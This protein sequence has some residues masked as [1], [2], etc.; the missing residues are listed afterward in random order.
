MRQMSDPVDHEFVWTWPGTTMRPGLCGHK[1]PVSNAVPCN[2]TARE[3]L[4]LVA[5]YGC[6]FCS[7]TA[8]MNVRCSC[9]D[10][11]SAAYCPA[12]AEDFDHTTIPVPIF[13]R[14]AA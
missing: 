9:T 13:E 8:G 5:N 10:P 11:C 3:H 14:R 2:R 6:R 4:V 1:A 12:D 7:T